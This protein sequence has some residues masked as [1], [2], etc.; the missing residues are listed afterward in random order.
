[1]IEFNNIEKKFGGIAALRGISFKIEEND[2]FGFVGPAASGKTTAIKILCGLMPPTSGTLTVEGIDILKQP[3]KIKSILGYIPDFEGDYDN[4]K[5]IEYMNF[6]SSAYGIHGNRREGLCHEILEMLEL[7]DSSDKYIE[8]LSRNQ[9]KRLC[10]ARAL[11]N[12]PKILI[13]DEPFS[14]LSLKNREK[15][16]EL[17]R[18]LNSLG[19]T[20]IITAHTLQE[21]AAL[22]GSIAAFEEGKVKMVGSILEIEKKM[23]SK[24]PIVM[25]VIKGQDIAIKVLKEDENVKNL[26]ISENDEI[27]IHFDGSS[28]EEGRLLLKVVLEGALVTSFSRKSRDMES[29]F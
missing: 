24:N 14:G 29:I 19:I 26:I 16:A 23:Q 2:I 20:I 22:C 9:R 6:F 8:E 4:L 17:L 28:D 25:K 12:D 1:M 15:I 11:V 21:A 3:N 7:C 13:V 5:V 27:L 10:I 18:Q